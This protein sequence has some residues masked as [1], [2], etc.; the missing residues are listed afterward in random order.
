M[1]FWI[2]QIS[3]PHSV[4]EYR[5]FSQMGNKINIVSECF[6]KEQNY[7]MNR[8]VTCVH[9]STKISKC[10][11]VNWKILKEEGLWLKTYQST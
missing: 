6:V 7:Y 5:I 8:W 10:Y 9:T 1:N 4:F 11:N 2:V 3:A